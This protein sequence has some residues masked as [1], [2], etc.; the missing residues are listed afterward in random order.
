MTGST[1]APEVLDRF[2]PAVRDWFLGTFHAPTAAQAHSWPA[3]ANG[4]NTLLLAPTGSGKTLAAFLAALD[5]LF[6][7]PAN[8]PPGVRVLYVSPLKALVYD[9]ER[10]LRS[11]L[12]GIANAAS[13]SG[14]ALR[15]VRVDVRTG[16]TSARERRIQAKEPAEI[17]VTTPES[18]YLILGSAAREALR[19]VDTVI[20]D[21]IHVMAGSKRGV[22]L[23]LSLERLA[24][25]TGK[26]PQRIGLS[27]TQRPLQEVALFLG[28]DRPVEIVDAAGPPRLDLQVVVPVEDMENPVVSGPAMSGGGEGFFQQVGGG[29]PRERRESDRR[30]EERGAR[31]DFRSE[32]K[33]ER[34]ESDRR[35][36]ER[37]ARSDFRSEQEHERRESDRRPEERGARSDF[38]S[39]QK[40][41][42]RES[43]RRPE[44]RGARSDFR[45]EQ[46]HEADP[47][48][49]GPDRLSAG[50]WPAIYPELLALVR[51]HRSTIIF[52]N[53]RLLCER[54]AKRLN[55]LAGEDLVLS[56]HGSL[57]HERRA[58]IEEALKQGKLPALVATSS[59]E[60]GIDM[61]AVDLV[62]L[63]ESP[64]SVAS[65]LQR[66]GRSGHSIDRTSIGRMFPKYRGDLVESA[67]VARE[68]QTAS[69]ESTRV[70]KNCLDVLAQQIVAMVAD[71]PWK[72]DELHA[73]IRRAY[74]YRE[75]TRAVLGSVLDMLSGKYPTDELSDLR[76]RLVWDRGTD[77]LTARK[78]AQQIALLNGGTIP[79]R[80]LYGVFVAGDGPRLGELDEE[81]VYETR[82]GDL[83]VLG[84]ST[85]RIEEITR[86]KVVVSP[87]PGEPGRLPFWHGERPGRPLDLGRKVGA[88]VREVAERGGKAAAWVQ[89][90]APTDERAARNVV[91]YVR[92]Q[93]EATG[94]VPSD[95]V[96]VVES[97]RDELGDW[98]TC[99]LSPFGARVHAPWALALEARFAQ[100][101]GYEVQALW[102]DD[103]LALRFAD[104]EE[105]PPTS[106]LWIDP[107]ELE[108]LVVEQLGKSALFAARFRE[109]A[110]RSLL[111]P[112]K[113]VKGRTPLW[114]QRLRAQHLLEV[115]SR[116]PSFPIVLETYRECLQDT[117][118]VPG[119]R[120]ILGSVRSR[121]IR[122]HE[123]ETR[124]P[125]PFARS[126][127]FAYVAAFMYAGDAPLAERKAMALTLDRS[128]LRELLGQEDLRDLLEPAAVGEVEAELQCLVPER[129]AR[130][131]DGLHDLLRKLGDLSLPEVTARCAEDPTEWVRQLEMARRIVPVR[132][133]GE[134]R[135]VAVEDVARFRDAVGVA[136]PPGLPLAFLQPTHDALDGLVARYARTHG[137]FLATAV[138]E[139]WGIPI[140]PVTTAL[141][142]LEQQGRIVFGEIRPG[143]TATE[144][145]DPEVLRRLKR[146]SLA[147]LRNQ[148]APVEAEVYARFLMQW[149]GV[150]ADRQGLGRLREVLDQLEGLPILASVLE[151]SVLPNRVRGFD[152]DLLDTLGAMGEVVWVGHGAQGP[153]D[154]RVA[155]Y[156]RERIAKLLDPPSVPDDLP[157]LHRALFEHL[158]S[159][160]ASFLVA[161]QQVVPGTPLQAVVDAVW[162]LVWMGLVTNDTFQPLRALR[163]RKKTGPR[164]PSAV[165]GRWSAVSELFAGPAPSETE[166]AHARA[167]VLLERYGVVCASTARHEGLVGGFS[168]VYPV[169]KVMEDTGRARRGWF[170]DGLDGAQFAA[171]GVVDRLRATREQDLDAVTVLDAADPANP[172]GAVL[173]WPERAG[174]QKARR[175]PGALVISVGARPVLFI[176]KGQRSWLT[177][178]GAEEPGLLRSAIDGW[179]AGMPD[180]W[181]TLTV[182][183]IDGVPALDSP[184]RGAL[185]EVGFVVGG[186]KL[187]LPRRR[188]ETGIG[189]GTSQAS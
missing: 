111:M 54:L 28:G 3:I 17:L 41:E 183:R 21:E 186:G 138:A 11:P 171:P 48:G 177:F 64:G 91:A 50:M 30:P 75:L 118:D 58:Q 13:R 12:V 83:I 68:M 143:G 84:A 51:K 154:G 148:I 26:D 131:A 162:D 34:R 170:V 49:K 42:R 142:A 189:W 63:V 119:L 5:R 172:W 166:K 137:P 1:A 147:A 92:D 52:T 116:Y 157:E 73:T 160:G 164:G 168:A 93:R 67:V 103:G 124:S 46:K 86:D 185:V 32:Q 33:H 141:R 122:V 161:L 144:W 125:S 120:E 101:G 155:L 14:R 182:E 108:E 55:E 135:W 65:G 25:L 15:P 27:A 158:Q 136:L 44:E 167:A 169:L 80:G 102:T 35:P 115:A 56:H 74:P 145:C 23:A 153:K 62:V 109:N 129:Q 173:A 123:V 97:F 176:E 126:L 43:D 7:L 45:S 181:R 94:E 66:V 128:L 96:I 38:R 59:L 2:D 79:D 133:A 152:G 85:W 81:M 61:G 121:A 95:Q 159:R 16:D 47:N 184:L 77:E 130:G 10:N 187:E 112:R 82:K 188:K 57:S 40:H 69:V 70:P 18:L 39:E 4:Q 100:R 36:E 29:I 53:S 140:G 146:R 60:L 105:L 165:G 106:E 8:T 151:E 107:D 87:A 149:H 88:F 110:A 180:R 19:T 31:S 76:P 37:G 78:G 98:R 99:V 104:T 113:T 178:V 127:V 150:G 175:V 89:E 71:R 114:A 179:L 24:A 134:P 9:I 139:R 163:A 6:R 90:V 174:T 22:H 132:I 156:R 72:V 20:I 117:L